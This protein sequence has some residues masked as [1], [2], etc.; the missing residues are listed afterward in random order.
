MNVITSSI[1]VS[2]IMGLF[3]Y[4]M[5]VAQAI[6]LKKN[7]ER[8]FHKKHPSIGNPYIVW[9]AIFIPIA[10]SLIIITSGIFVEESRKVQ[11]EKLICIESIQEWQEVKGLVTVT[12]H[13]AFINEE[14]DLEFEIPHQ[15]VKGDCFM[16]Y[17]YK[18]GG[19]TL[20]KRE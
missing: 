4:Y 15:Y 20:E 6:R 13:H 10:F 19:W 17:K 7:W 16:I 11:D 5:L 18:I 14:Y 9:R 8:T 1:I 3:S 2:V 12:Y